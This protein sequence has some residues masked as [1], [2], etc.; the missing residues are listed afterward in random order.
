[1]RQRHLEIYNFFFSKNYN[2][3]SFY[4]GYEAGKIRDD[5]LHRGT[6]KPRKGGWGKSGIIKV[7]YMPFVI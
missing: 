3:A 6:V 2:T 7:W 5:L 4:E 1:M